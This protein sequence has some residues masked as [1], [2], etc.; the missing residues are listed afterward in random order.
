MAERA[1]R[2]LEVFLSCEKESKAEL[3]TNLK[4]ALLQTLQKLSVEELG[5]DPK[6]G[7]ITQGKKKSHFNI[8]LLVYNLLRR[9]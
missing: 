5:H 2:V 8:S 1:L 7:N 6:E 3:C 4:P 9:G